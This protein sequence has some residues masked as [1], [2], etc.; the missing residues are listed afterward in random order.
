MSEVKPMNLSGVSHNPLQ[1]GAARGSVSEDFREAER[2]RLAKRQLSNQEHRSAQQLIIQKA[3]LGMQQQMN[4]YRVKAM[5][6][7]EQDYQKKKLAENY[8][9]SN[10]PQPGQRTLDS[11]L[12][13]GL[14]YGIG[15]YQKAKEKWV[16]EV[17]PHSWQAFE[18]HYQGLKQAEMQNLQNSMLYDSRSNMTEGQHRKK[19]QEMLQKMDPASR[20]NFLNSLD[21]ST[22]QIIESKFPMHKD[23]G[24]RWED[25]V[26]DTGLWIGENPIKTTLGGASAI[27]ATGFA[28]RG[29]PVKL[30]NAL[31][32][33]NGK[34][35][36]EM[37]EIF[38]NASIKMGDK[39]GKGV[40]SLEDI[41]IAVKD[42][43]LTKAQAKILKDGGRVVPEM[44]KG[45]P[46][47]VSN[48]IGPE[49]VSHKN[50]PKVK[51]DINALM[52]DGVLD[53]KHADQLKGV[54]DDIVRKGD[55]LTSENVGKYLAKKP[56]QFKGL[57]KSLE[58]G[59]SSGLMQKL[60][61]F[62]ASG[63]VK[64][65]GTLGVGIA[66]ASALEA[67]FEAM[68]GD[69]NPN[70]ETWGDIGNVG[71]FNVGAGA[72][73]AIRTIQNKINTHG[74]AKVMQMVAKK[75]GPKLAARLLAKGALTGT[76][77]GSVVGG[78]MLA[79]EAAYIAYLISTME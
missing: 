64:G 47:P 74:L 25:F 60:G 61:G 8:I 55:D 33:N 48:M 16:R 57:I 75:G 22:R 31:F 52:K 20:Q 21:G 79:A 51:E 71:G 14:T 67:G 23:V 72:L 78:A 44:F 49:R 63:I 9:F 69:D 29:A 18:K 10:Y 32:R 36:K 6:R 58:H 43:A 24:R 68:A 39:T 46:G 42:G 11:F 2:I 56:D 45:K 3:Q 15:G 40:I 38:K 27:I 41:D 77:V 7:A 70:Q 65:I 35:T 30:V 19:Y 54:I 62:S 28:L 50:I 13:D 34:V 4:E 59:T 76:G 26:T 5:E 73:G 1:G 66:G 12:K 37:P 17:G 53:Q